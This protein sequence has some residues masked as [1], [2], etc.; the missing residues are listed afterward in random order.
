MRMIEAKRARKLLAVMNSQV[1][2]RAQSAV[3][4][5]VAHGGHGKSI[6]KIEINE[7]IQ[8]VKEFMLSTVIGNWVRP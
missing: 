5:H 6:L 8:K 1:F 2:S 4:P 7:A 3:A